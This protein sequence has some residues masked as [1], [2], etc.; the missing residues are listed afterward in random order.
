[1]PEINPYE[2]PQSELKQVSS[3][4]SRA[5]VGTTI[6]RYFVPAL[7]GLQIAAGGLALLLDSTIP[8]FSFN[9]GQRQALIEVFLMS[10]LGLGVLLLLTALIRGALKLIIFEVIT[11]VL[12]IW[13]SLPTIH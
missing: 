8:L 4:P 13:W 1:M 6:G 3:E 9:H 12:F 10:V 7:V 11:L 2:P 5:A